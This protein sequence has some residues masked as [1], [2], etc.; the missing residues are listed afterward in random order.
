MDRIVAWCIALIVALP[1]FAA[2]GQDLMVYPTRVVMSDKVRT[3]QVDIINTGQTQT[4][5]KIS[6]VRKRMTEAGDFQEAAVAE[7]GEKFADDLV[8]FS[9]RQ[10]T[11][12]PGAGQTVRIL[13]KVP[14]DLGEGEYRSHLVFSKMA[15]GIAEVPE[16]KDRDP[17]AV[18]MRISTNVGVSIPVIVRHG[19]LV[20]EAAIDPASV[21]VTAADPH[22]QR[23]TLTL[24]RAGSRSIYGNIAVYRGKEKVALVDNFAV[25]V[26]NSRRKVSVPVLE[27]HQ[28]KPGDS[29][30]VVFTEKGE[31]K[32]LAEAAAV[33]R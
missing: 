5:Y 17:K 6:L 14:P 33:V 1:H 2:A 16:P 21:A 20:A 22:A 27:P 23:I 25:Y 3:A 28:L 8:K 29:L 32:P 19:Q 7:P 9:P 31:S 10:V 30:H 26:P 18:S 24:S 12:V 15:S 4:S 11:L 13:F